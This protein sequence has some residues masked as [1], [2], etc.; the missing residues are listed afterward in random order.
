MKGIEFPLRPG[1][2]PVIFR[3]GIKAARDLERAAGCNY[4][5]L[6]TRHQQVEALCLLTCYCLK[7][8][9]PTMTVD[10]ATDLLELYVDKGGNMATLT[11]AL[12]QAVNLSGAYG[13]PEPEDAARPTTA[14]E[15]APA[16]SG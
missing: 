1:E 16:T 4:L 3:F 9:D 12:M 10:K 11:T 15:T 14:G 5:Q 6:F 2:I 8:D 7:H 13:T